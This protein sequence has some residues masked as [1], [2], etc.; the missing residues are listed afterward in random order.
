MTD[1]DWK[2]RAEAAERTVSVL[3]DKVRALYN[4]N[5]KTAIQRQLERARE[6]DE[7][8]RRRQELMQVRAAELARH[9]LVTRPCHPSGSRASCELAAISTATRW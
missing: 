1:I 8:N 7:A 6:R 5:A 4:G 2:R 9:V 3:K